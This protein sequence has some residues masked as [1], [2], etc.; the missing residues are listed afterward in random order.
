MCWHKY[1][2]WELYEVRMI[3]SPNLFWNDSGEMIHFI[4]K[5]ERRHCTKCGKNQDR[6]VG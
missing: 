3:R 2:K 6:K 5:H 4:E 1:T